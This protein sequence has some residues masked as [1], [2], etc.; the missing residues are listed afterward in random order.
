VILMKKAS[1]ILPLTEKNRIVRRVLTIL[2][3]VRGLY[4]DISIN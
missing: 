3:R 4:G 1:D 2:S